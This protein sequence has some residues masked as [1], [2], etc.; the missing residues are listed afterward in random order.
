MPL[1]DTGCI[2]LPWLPHPLPLLLGALDILVHAPHPS[3]RLEH[4]SRRLDHDFIHFASACMAYAT[5]SNVCYFAINAV[6]NL[7]CALKQFEEKVRSRRNQTRIALCRFCK[8]VTLVSLANLFER[9]V[10]YCVS[11]R[12]VFHANKPNYNTLVN[13]YIVNYFYI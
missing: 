4:W 13:I 12:W 3:K 9:L 8:E 7:E 11:H 10:L 2:N 1:D 5:S 6:Y